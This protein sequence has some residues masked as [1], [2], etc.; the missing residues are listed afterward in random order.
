VALNFI[1]GDVT[2][3]G[4][5]LMHPLNISSMPLASLYVYMYSEQGPIVNELQIPSG[6]T[7]NVRK[8]DSVEVLCKRK[9]DVFKITVPLDDSGVRTLEVGST[10][11]VR[12]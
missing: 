11:Y 3:A 5:C 10:L 4:A 7:E 8:E 2:L 9:V 6:R 12:S 1:S